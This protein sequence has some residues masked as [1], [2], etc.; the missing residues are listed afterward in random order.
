MIDYKNLHW[1]NSDALFSRVKLGHGGNETRLELFFP[2]G[3][4]DS[5][6]LFRKMI[7]LTVAVPR[8]GTVRF[9][10]AVALTRY[11]L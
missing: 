11:D 1:E 10:P 3:L 2:F 6:E 8:H 7:R 9:S 5:V 4:M